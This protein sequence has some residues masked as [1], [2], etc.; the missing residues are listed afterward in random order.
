V[1]SVIA[2]LKSLA[3]ILARTEVRS[4]ASREV[5]TSTA[6]AAGA[7]KNAATRIANSQSVDVFTIDLHVDDG[8]GSG[9]PHV[10]ATVSA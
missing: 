6:S 2:A 3:L 1:S 7:A 10:F 9:A 5:T 8:G 4:G